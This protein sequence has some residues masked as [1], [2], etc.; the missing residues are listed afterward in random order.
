MNNLNSTC[1]FHLSLLRY[2]IPTGSVARGHLDICCME[3]T[4]RR[5]FAML[6]R[7]DRERRTRQEEQWAGAVLIGSSQRRLAGTRFN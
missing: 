1:S 3:G 4:G 5:E 6:W 2:D 7:K